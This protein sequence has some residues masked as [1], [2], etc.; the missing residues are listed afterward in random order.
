MKLNKI[1]LL[2][3]AFVLM[4]TAS[5]ESVCFASEISLTSK[6][7]CAPYAVF[8]RSEGVCYTV[9]GTSEGS[10]LLTDYFGNTQSGTF[11]DGEILINNLDVGHYDLNLTSGTQTFETEFAV[12]PNK[13]DRRDSSFNPL[14]FSAMATYTYTT[15]NVTNYDAYAKTISLA[16]VNY[17]REF[18]NWKDLVTDSR[19]LKKNKALIDAYN[20]NNIGVMLMIQDMP[21]ENARGTQYYENGNCITY[22][23]NIPYNAVKKMLDTFSGKIDAIEV[24]NE[25][26]DMT[27]MDTADRYASVLKVASIAA[28]QDNNIKISNAGI[29]K[30]NSIFAQRLL[31]N[32]ING[33]IDI[34]DTH[35]Y[36]NYSADEVYIETPEGISN[37]MGDATSY[38]LTNKKLW[39]SEYGFRAA[40]DS[41]E[42]LDLSDTQIIQAAKTAPIALIRAH[43]SGVDKMFWFIHGYLKEDGVNGYG[44]FSSTHTPNYVYSALS[45]F[46]NAL[47][48]AGY[49]RE[50]EADGA[51]VCIYS[52]G[53][54]EIACVWSEN[55][56]NITLPVN[57]GKVVITDIMGREKVVN[58]ENS[59]I[60]IMAT[61][62]IQ[63][64]RAVNG[65][66]DNFA[67][68]VKYEKESVRP[69]LSNAQRVVMTP[70][71][72][73]DALAMA[74]SRAYSLDTSDGKVNEVKLKV[75]NFNTVPM[76]VNVECISEGGWTVENS[77][78]TVTV[79]ARAA[80]DDG[81]EGGL[82]TVIFNISA[83]EDTDIFNNTPLVFSAVVEGEKVS[84]TVTYI[85]SK[86]V[87]N[88]IIDGCNDV[89]A[90]SLSKSGTENN[91]TTSTLE[92]AESGIKMTC[93][94]DSATKNKACRIEYNSA[95]SIDS[96]SVG[97]SF[98]CTSPQ[99]PEAML[100]VW[101]T[102][103]DNDTF[104]SSYTVSLDAPLQ[105]G[106]DYTYVFP[107]E[108]FK[109]GYGTGN[110]IL[111]NGTAKI[112]IGIMN[113]TVDFA[114]Y[115]FKDFGIVQKTNEVINGIDVTELSYQNAVLTAKLSSQN[116]KSAR[117]MVLGNVFEGVVTGNNLTVNLL[118][119]AATHK[120][121]IFMYDN[122]NRVY[123]TT[124]YITVP[125][126]EVPDIKNQEGVSDGAFVTSGGSVTVR[127]KTL[128]A[129]ANNK[130]SLI[131]YPDN[132]SPQDVTLSDL[133]FVDEILIDSQGMYSFSFNL[134]DFDPDC[135]YSYTLNAGGTPIKSTLEEYQ[136]TYEWSGAE[137]TFF[138]TEKSVKVVTAMN[139]ASQDM[140]FIT[141]MYSENGAL[142]Q[143]FGESLLQSE[144][145]QKYEFEYIIPDGTHVIKTFVWS[146]DGKI[147][148]LQIPCISYCK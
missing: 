70:E 128:K 27:E 146:A 123:K 127:G 89:E 45:A 77:A 19:H 129:Y 30:C 12:V 59:S 122:A 4:I 87:N 131:V 26:D 113:P 62:D 118:L 117:L 22:D 55:T 112:K 133:V 132:I 143:I 36:R 104:Y 76:T 3:V 116:A 90:W 6:A 58:I 2:V 31:Q 106:D 24:L 53:A 140:N 115:Y 56:T 64:I 9:T 5:F 95:I 72:N 145:A 93:T 54:E 16:G 41:T 65:F 124:D 136:V 110:K 40:L 66:S 11:K 29:A 92:Q 18:I 39:M 52:E 142:T 44:T 103:V 91:T 99:V 10:Y 109:W 79:P 37:F 80:N 121:E 20:A 8:Q 63:Y 50:F 15:N 88:T 60:E 105:A 86:E 69:A 43:K 35:L 57:N 134:K 82:A 49:S 21:G 78:H 102:D 141:G 147:T 135:G 84:D 23:L 25:P 68:A 139:F 107:F 7:E 71:F 96:E 137:I 46:T 75:Y 42:S 100:R 83:N 101:M 111:D 94:F 13:Q 51:N 67:E 120:T 81:I 98:K 17:V 125:E 32:D 85:T 126:N 48:N 74:A 119:P 14:A 144:D 148:P 138:R 130:A 28:E 61:S 33:Y 108:N 73:D 34:Y 38:G 1:F 47:G 114:E 97:L